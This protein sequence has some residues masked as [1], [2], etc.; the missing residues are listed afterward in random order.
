M[1]KRKPGKAFVV[2]GEKILVN[3]DGHAGTMILFDYTGDFDFAVR[4]G[5]EFAEKHRETFSR[6]G[7]LMVREVKEFLKENQRDVKP[8]GAMYF[9]NFNPTR[10]T[11]CTKAY[12]AILTLWDYTGDFEYAL[13]WYKSFMNEFGII[14]KDLLG[15][16]IPL[17]QMKA[18]LKEHPAPQSRK[19]SGVSSP[20]TVTA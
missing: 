1:K 20:H 7:I 18:F 17:P 3:V 15:C 6:Q 5:G 19:Q 13:R 8:E 12:A 14:F 10:I 2:D 4:Q 16:F 11:V 9:F